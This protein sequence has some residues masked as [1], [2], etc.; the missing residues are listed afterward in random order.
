MVTP[1]NFPKNS[2][3]PEMSLQEKTVTLEQIPKTLAPEGKMSMFYSFCFG[4]PIS[5]LTALGKI[6]HD[7]KEVTFVTGMTLAPYEILKKPTTKLISGYYSGVER[8]LSAGGCQVTY[9]PR[10]FHTF[11]RPITEAIKPEWIATTTTPMD[12]QGY[13]N[14]GVTGDLTEWFIRHRLEGKWNTKI[15]VEVSEQMPTILGF[16]EFGN[17]Q[18]HHK[19]VDLIVTGAEKRPIPEHPKV[20]PTKEDFEIA[21]F[22]H[23]EVGNGACI[24]IGI[25]RLPDAI[26]EMLDDH[27]NLSFHTEMLTTC[28]KNLMESGAVTNSEKNLT[29]PLYKLYNNHTVFTFVG[30]TKDLY[31]FVDRNPDTRCVPLNH[32][33]DPA[34]ISMHD[35]FVAINAILGCDL[36]GQTISTAYG[37]DGTIHQYSGIGGQATFVRA[38]QDSKNGKSFQCMPST[39]EVNGK[40]QSNI[41]VTFPEGIPIGTPEYFTDYVVTEYGAARLWNLGIKDRAKALIKI[42][43]PDFRDQLEK[44]AKNRGLL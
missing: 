33:N 4:Q 39:R 5:T 7:W 12:D 24:Q 3:A 37:W 1:T 32:L 27:K 26:G 38:A 34:I 2:S 22:V 40:I 25:G 16:P 28:V 18:V 15:L 21:R 31:K 42:A 8:A 11:F 13:F 23:D 44:D 36:R 29:H 20:Q 43:H 14:L 6:P 35:N 19:D 30:G 10:E 17:H 9:F 41:V